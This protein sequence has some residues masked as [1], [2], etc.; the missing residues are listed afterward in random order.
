MYSEECSE[1]GIS[2]VMIIVTICVFAVLLVIAIWTVRM[3]TNYKKKIQH[4]LDEK[5]EQKA[6]KSAPEEEEGENEEKVEQKE[7]EKQKAEE[8]K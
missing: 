3:A 7:P 5:A 6:L 1:M 4:V 8:K 2:Y